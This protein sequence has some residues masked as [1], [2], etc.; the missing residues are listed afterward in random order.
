MRGKPW[1]VTQMIKLGDY[2]NKA[3]HKYA[4][5]QKN[6]LLLQLLLLLGQEENLK[7]TDKNFYI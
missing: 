2:P 3:V 1:S 6:L 7:F 5:E 4:S